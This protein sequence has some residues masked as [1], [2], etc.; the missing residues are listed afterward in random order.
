MVCVD[1]GISPLFI[2]SFSLATFFLA[3][4]IDSA[5]IF[6]AVGWLS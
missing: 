3:K 1:S 5:S 4:A 6:P 2:I